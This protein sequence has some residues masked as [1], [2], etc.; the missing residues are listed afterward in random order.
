MLVF[1]KPKCHLLRMSLS[2]FVKVEYN[3][4]G[5]SINVSS[6]RNVIFCGMLSDAQTLMV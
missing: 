2:L 4:K 6:H 1:N 5:T 3:L